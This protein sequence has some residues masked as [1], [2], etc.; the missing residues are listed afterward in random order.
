[1]SIWSEVTIIVYKEKDTKMGFLLWRIDTINVAAV[2]EF[3]RAF[4]IKRVLM[5]SRFSTYACTCWE[6]DVLRSQAQRLQELCVKHEDLYNSEKISSF[7]YLVKFEERSF[8]WL[9][10]GVPRSFACGIQL[11]S[12]WQH[13]LLIQLKKSGCFR[14]KFFCFILALL[15]KTEGIYLF[16]F[17]SVEIRVWACLWTLLLLEW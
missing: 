15:R 16:V 1:M 3:D 6:M 12:P 7:S 11:H 14:F 2:L 8:S 13:H 9:R 10:T 5:Y 17:I 4:V